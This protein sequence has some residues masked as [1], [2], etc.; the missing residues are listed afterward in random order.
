MGYYDISLADVGKKLC[1]LN[2]PFVKYECNHLPMGVCIAPDIFQEQMS[3]LVENLESVRFYIDYF[4]VVTPG[5]C[6]EDLS[7]VEEVMK[8]L[9]S[10]GLKFK[11]DKCKFVVPKVEYLGYITMREGIKMD[12]KKIESVINLERPKDKNRWGSS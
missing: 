6:E 9:Q 11:I 1:T 3:A 8:Q 12:L 5:S 7:K 2:T 4:L 10:D